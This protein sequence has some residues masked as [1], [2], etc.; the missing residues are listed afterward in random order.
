MIVG[1][2]AAGDRRTL[3]NLLARE[4]YDGFDA[5]IR[6]RESK[7]ETVES[8]FVS[9]ETAE[10]TAPRCAERPRRSPCASSRN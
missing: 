8:R 9:L 7:G 4:V 5:A 10:I 3:K 6:E 2:F 1:A